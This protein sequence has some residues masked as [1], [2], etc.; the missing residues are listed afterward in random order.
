MKEARTQCNDNFKTLGERGK[1]KKKKR[2]P[3]NLESYPVK[4]CF[5]SEDK[6]FVLANPHRASDHWEKGTTLISTFNPPFSLRSFS[7]HSKGKEYKQ[8]QQIPWVEETE[9]SMWGCRGDWDLE[10]RV[11]EMGSCQALNLC[12][13]TPLGP[14]L[15]AFRM[16]DAPRGKWYQMLTS[17]FYLS[18][19]SWLHTEL[20][21]LSS[22]FKY[23]VFF[24][25]LASFSICSQES[26]SKSPCPPLL[27]AEFF[28][29]VKYFGK[30]ILKAWINEGIYHVHGL[31][32]IL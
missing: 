31:G 18:F 16:G 6:K 13:G 1:K 17:Y 10:G 28:L 23:G 27:E 8:K 29:S 9:T 22:A 11:L 7:N 15:T 25:T 4:M 5:K 32:H 24:G 2:K 30:K 12:K 3:T 20:W 26:D 19:E 21:Q 14:W